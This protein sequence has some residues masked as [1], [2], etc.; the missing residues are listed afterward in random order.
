MKL[1]APLALL[2]L[3]AMLA[4]GCGSTPPTRYYELQATARGHGPSRPLTIVVEPVTIPPDVD[5]PQIV[6]GGPGDEVAIEDFH[7]WAAPLQDA[8]ALVV[9]RNLAALVGAE[10]VALS[11][12]LAGPPKY[13]VRISIRSFG[14]RLGDAAAVDARWSV[15]R[16][17]G[18]LRSGH[19]TIR[20]PVKAAGFDALASAH[21]AAA[22]RLSADIAD[23]ILALELRS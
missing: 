13:R 18:L 5:R 20:V 8:L 3:A 7:R 17:D 6:L 1:L 19:A 15:R 4:A 16:D 12:E 23:A 2:C 11:G 21:S 14:S 10:D 22:E 9:S